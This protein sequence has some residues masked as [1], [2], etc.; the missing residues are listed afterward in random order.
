MRKNRFLY[1][2][3][4]LIGLAGMTYFVA[5]RVLYPNYLMESKPSEMGSEVDDLFLETVYPITALNT[6]ITLLVWNE[7]SMNINSDA[8][9]YLMT[10]LNHTDEPVEFADIEFEQAFFQYD[11]IQKRWNRLYRDVPAMQQ[12]TILPPHME[13]KDMV[14]V[15]IIVPANILG[16]NRGQP[17]RIFVSGIGVNSK[18][19]YGAYLDINP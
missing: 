17:F 5:S 18:Q 4:I 19:P 9:S 2:G 14:D 7:P 1:L 16:L 6:G 3:V 12:V 13:R 8:I 15:G 11:P 10:A